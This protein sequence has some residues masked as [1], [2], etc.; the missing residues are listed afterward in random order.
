LYLFEYF[1]IFIKIGIFIRKKTPLARI[2]NPCGDYF[3]D[4]AEKYYEVNN[5][6]KLIIIS[7]EQ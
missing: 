2:C 7:D 1:S 5:D 3:K 4:K 6:S